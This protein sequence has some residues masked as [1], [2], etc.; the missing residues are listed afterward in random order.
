MIWKERVQ[1]LPF[2]PV[3]DARAEILRPPRFLAKPFELAHHLALGRA[4]RA[5]ESFVE[6][7]ERIRVAFQ[8]FS[9]RLLVARKSSR[10]PARQVFPLHLTP[11]MLPAAQNAA[12][13]ES[14]FF[15]QS[16]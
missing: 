1:N 5:S 13:L 11:H 8:D 7:R 16:R 14:V 6:L 12:E 3:Q 4:Q 15:Q 2:M 10:E 9:Q